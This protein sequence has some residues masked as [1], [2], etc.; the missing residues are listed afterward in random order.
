M[1]PDDP[2]EPAM[3]VERD[4]TAARAMMF[5]DPAWALPRLQQAAERWRALGNPVKEAWAY[6]NAGVASF[7]LSRMEE[8]A[9]NLERGLELFEQAGDRAGAVSAS[10]VLCLARPTDRRV[11]GWLADALEFAEAAGDRQR[12]VTTLTTLAWHHFFRSFCGSAQDMAEA[13]G[14]A[15]RLADLAGE[16]GMGELAVQG[17]SL[18]AIMARFS[19]RLDEAAAHVTAL[20]REASGFHDKDPWLGWAASFSVTVASGAPGATPPFPPDTSPDPVVGM[21]GLLIE[22]E[23]TMSG[24]IDEA[25][26]RLESA[27]RP[28]LG[29][30]ADLVGVMDAL[31]LVLGGRRVDAR[32]WAE[33]AAGAARVLQ[34]P[35]AATAADALLAEIAADKDGLPPAPAVAASLT[36]ALVLRAHVVSG[37]RAAADALRQATSTLAMPGLLSTL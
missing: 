9:A 6:A 5:T 25:L 20:A 24:R 3:V 35:A 26:S 23:L 13:E 16:L 4:H 22:A 27:E 30:I 28:N 1:I 29:P 18:L 17:W 7:Y 2:S 19:G 15:R 31:A 10:S 33:R 36:D 34:A 8:S 11:P 21:A 14:F 12:Q 32:P 37:D